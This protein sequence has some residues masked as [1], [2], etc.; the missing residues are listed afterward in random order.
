MKVETR[1]LLKEAWKYCDENDKSTEFMLQ[2]MQ[3][4]AHVNLDTVLVFLEK[5][6]SW[7]KVP[8]RFNWRKKKKI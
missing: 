8:G 7:S 4:V 2:Y 1:L 6:G 3:D 5:Y